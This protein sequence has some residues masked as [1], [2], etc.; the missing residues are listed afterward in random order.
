MTLKQKQFILAIFTSIS[1]EDRG[2]NV[3][4]EKEG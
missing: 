2:T 4:E 3:E 1:K